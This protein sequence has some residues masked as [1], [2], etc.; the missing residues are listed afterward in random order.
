[1]TVESATDII[2][3]TLK[4]YI[5]FAKGVKTAILLQYVRVYV[6]R[7]KKT[8]YPWYARKDSR[9]ST[10]AKTSALPTIPVTWNKV[11]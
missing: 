6:K 3:F 7:K 8:T 9:N 4:E 10:Q 11:S 1:L 5:L 2:E